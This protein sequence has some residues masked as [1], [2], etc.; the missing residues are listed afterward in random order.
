MA[1][2]PQKNH[3]VDPAKWQVLL[4]WGTV[5]KITCLQTLTLPLEQAI[6]NV[7]CRSTEDDEFSHNWESAN[8]IHHWLKLIQ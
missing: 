1:A 5:H 4:R 8:R 2:G 7:V 6:N 3:D